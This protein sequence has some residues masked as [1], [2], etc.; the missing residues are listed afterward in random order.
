MAQQCET[1]VNLQRLI[2]RSEELA[3]RGAGLSSADVGRFRAY[4]RSMLSM[5]QSLKEQSL[6]RL[7]AENVNNYQRKI[8]FL[9]RFLDLESRVAHPELLPSE[10]SVGGTMLTNA[11]L[12]EKEMQQRAMQR[13][14]NRLRAELLGE[15]KRIES[16]REDAHTHA[17]ERCVIVSFCLL[18]FLANGSLRSLA[19]MYRAYRDG[20][21]YEALLTHHRG[22]HE[23]LAENMV[24]MALHLKHNTLMSSQIIKDDVKTLDDSHKVAEHNVK[25]LREEGS[26]LKEIAAAWSSW[27]IYGVLA[28]VSLVFVWTV[29]FIRL[30]PS[31]MSG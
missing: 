2:C 9:Q 7:T 19:E 31:G 25:R 21:S 26:R 16:P 28:V 8:D 17:A 10:Y 13:K 6:S 3:S 1:E 11:S 30:F 27:W 20:D 12:K 15:A 14:V 22:M 24:Q 23:N 18:L 29:L 5:I 4:V